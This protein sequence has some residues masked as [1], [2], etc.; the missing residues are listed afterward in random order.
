MTAPR[1]VAEAGGGA[2]GLGEGREA[3]GAARG[4]VRTSPG[5]S[6]GLACDGRAMVMLPSMIMPAEP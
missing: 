6:A 2:V 5:G 1:S 3:E 4:K